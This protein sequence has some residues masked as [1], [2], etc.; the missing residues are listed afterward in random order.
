[1]QISWD[2]EDRTRSARWRARVPLRWRWGV[3]V[4]TAIVLTI[5]ALIALVLEMEQRAWS[6]QEQ[7]QA[8]M[9][10]GVI[11]NSITLPMTM[12][13]D[14]A[15]QRILQQFIEQIP[16]IQQIY[17]VWHSGF[18]ESY[19]EGVIPP[20][21]HSSKQESLTA[22]RIQVAG[23]WFTTTVHYGGQTM[24]RLNVRFSGQKWRQGLQEMRN[25]MLMVAGVV[26]LLAMLGVYSLARQMSRPLE[27]L[28]TATGR[29]AKG[30]LSVSLPVTSNDEIGDVTARFNRMV[31]DLEHKEQVRDRFGKYLHPE[32][33]ASLFEEGERGPI[34]QQ[35][36]VTVLFADMVDFTNFSHRCS[37]EK[38]VAVIN[39]FFELF[40]FVIAA[41]DGH[42]DKYIGDAV[43]AV[44]N[45]PF[46]H[47]NHTEQA[48]LAALAMTQICQ[49]L[50]MRR[51]NG[52]AV[53]F[54]VGLNCGEVIV[55]NIGAS[56]RL[57]F[58]LIGD[59]VNVASRMAGIGKENQ[60]IAPA[61][62][63]AAAR[64]HNFELR[65]LGKLKVKGIEQ[66]I[67]CVRVV[68]RDADLRL[69]VDEVVAAAFDQ[70]PIRP[71]LI[72]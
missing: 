38:V 47:R 67:A 28:A 66:P 43:M 65:E 37:P 8:R 25:R 29:V 52:E 72:G 23:L 26:F 63:F 59:A 64:K 18:V 49:R 13:D 5:V 41:F 7:K 61:A 19:G 2:S 30:D 12:H 6:T 1:M 69:R 15:T 55:G 48:A 58:T 62:S 50:N 46:E 70:V 71:N 56:K 39:Q 54:R 60:V 40:H 31:I 44:F 27:V 16:E 57:E 35:R 17:L 34:S 20:A 3:F 21:V 14:H 36:E 9:L 10:V 24:G 51:P 22:V 4:G 42:V 45:H 33:V 11:K 32:L 53:A 68:V